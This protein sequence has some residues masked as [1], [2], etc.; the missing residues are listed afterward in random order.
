MDVYAEYEKK[1]CTAQAAVQ[2]VKDGDW[3]D[4]SQCTSCPL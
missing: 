3:V 4:Y 1:R 2:L